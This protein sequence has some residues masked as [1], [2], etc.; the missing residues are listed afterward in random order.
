MISMQH[1]TVQEAVNLFPKPSFRK[2][3][4]ETVEAIANSFNSGY[5]YVFLRAPVGS[6]KSADLTTFCRFYQSFYSTPQLALIKQI[7]DD[8]DLGMYFHDIKGQNNYKCVKSDDPSDTVRHGICKRVKGFVPKYC[9]KYVECPYYSMKW[10]AS[11][12]QSILTSTAYIML[13]ALNHGDVVEAPML[14]KRP[15]QVIDEGHNLAEIILGF[16]SVSLTPNTLKDLYYKHQARFVAV[17]NLRLNEMKAL[18]EEIHT[19]VAIRINELEEQQQ[20]VGLT[21]LNL[22]DKAAIEEIEQ[23]N[24]VSNTIGNILDSHEDGSWVWY[25]NYTKKHGQQLPCFIAQPLSARNYAQH[26]IWRRSDIGIVSSATLD[27]DI[28]INETGLDTVCKREEINV[29]DVPSTFAPENRPIVDWS[30]RVGKMTRAE[31]GDN[32]D[33]AVECIAEIAVKHRGQN[34]AVHSSSYKLAQD[35]YDRYFSRYIIPFLTGIT[36]TEFPPIVIAQGDT[37][38]DTVKRWIDDGRAG[39]GGILMAVALSEGQDWKGDAC[40]AQ[41][42]LNTLYPS[43]EDKRIHKRVVE[44]KHSRWYNS[45]TMNSIMQSYGRGVRSE[46]D[47]CTMYLLDETVFTVY[48]SL[49]NTLPIWFTEIMEPV[50]K[51]AKKRGL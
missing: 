11:Q 46:D 27:P 15:L 33:K 22:Q 25:T 23:L 2:Y 18:L 16:V 49:K 7:L 17:E 4:R 10:A 14:S 31:R 45:M 9:D 28:F 30:W 32:I 44:L 21:K 29:L 50:A 12:S 43:L 51:E 5:K 41:I 6:G 48:K 24:N 8:P 42:L 19:D 36:V 13:E 26:Y 3:Q 38:H 47:Y 37:K 35:V 39:K 1:I 40:R 20:E 34:V